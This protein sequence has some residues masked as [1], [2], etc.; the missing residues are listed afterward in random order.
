MK[1]VF[2][3]NNIVAD[4]DYMKKKDDNIQYTIYKLA[5][6]G[7]DVHCV[8][9][10]KL[11]DFEYRGIKFHFSPNIID[12]I[13]SLKPDALFVH[14]FNSNLM[15]SCN[16]IP[17]RKIV[18][19]CGGHIFT[20]DFSKYDAVIVTRHYQKSLINHPNVVVIPLGVDL[21]SF[22]PENVEKKWDVV[23]VAN[24]VPAKRMHILKN[25]QS[26]M[27]FKMLIIGRN[28]EKTDAPNLD[29][30]SCLNKDIPKYLNASK[31]F[32]MVSAKEDTGPRAVS[33]ATACGLPIITMIDSLGIQ[34]IV[35]RA[36]CGFIAEH[37]NFQELLEGL[38]KDEELRNRL[39]KNA[40]KYAEEHFDQEKNYLL[41]KQTILGDE[42]V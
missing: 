27:K 19:D 28:Y 41:Y 17:C 15:Y 16:N 11:L 35:A 22:K 3:W 39:G 23:C 34:S 1:I 20:F 36:D 31:V 40:R 30:I 2:A 26:R 24:N 29:I 8:N 4:P 5:E 10:G 33:E 25:F 7:Y 9:S 18:Q 13:L 38:L 21:K 32:A 6:E 37:F 12:T 14:E 42:N